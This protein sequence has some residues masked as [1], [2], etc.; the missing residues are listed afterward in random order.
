MVGIKALLDS[1]VVDNAL[2]KDILWAM[3]PRTGFQ[4][5]A[6]D[7]N[8]GLTRAD[9]RGPP[10]PFLDDKEWRNQLRSVDDSAGKKFNDLDLKQE[11]WENGWVHARGMELAI[12]KYEKN[13]AKALTEAETV[14]K[15]DSEK[16]AGSEKAVASDKAGVFV[17]DDGDEEM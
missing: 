13:K 15:D 5:V 17:D 14:A 7:P 9:C 4:P 1:D 8:V 12:A 3:T 2:K 10:P 16:A 6:S 11:L